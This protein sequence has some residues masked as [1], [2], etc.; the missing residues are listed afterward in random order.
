[1]MFIL[2][3]IWEE[4]MKINT[5]PTIRRAAQEEMSLIVILT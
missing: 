4:K 5:N 2:E 1:M 3:E